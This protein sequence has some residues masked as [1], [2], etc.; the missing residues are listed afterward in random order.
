M[1]IESLELRKYLFADAVG[2]LLLCARNAK[3][4]M[5][6]QPGT[7]K[8]SAKVTLRN[9][10][11]RPPCGCGTDMLPHGPCRVLTYRDFRRQLRGM[12]TSLTPTGN[13]EHRIQDIQE[14]DEAEV[15]RR[16]TGEKEEER[17]LHRVRETNVAMAMMLAELQTAN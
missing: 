15:V 8:H 13:A 6:T 5:I 3:P 10:I 16:G 4:R 12:E 1:L 11:S 14:T 2:S 9:V 7:H 17:A